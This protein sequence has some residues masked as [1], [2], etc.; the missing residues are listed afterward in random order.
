M[1]DQKADKNNSPQ[2]GTDAVVER[3]REF[4]RSQLREGAAPPRLSFALALVATEM[5]LAIASDP[6][7]VFPVVL[8]GITR[9][10]SNRSEAKVLQD[11]ECSVEGPA[12]PGNA[13][14]H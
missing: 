2:L 7:R 11:E 6:V 1:S 5:G 13:T 12:S 14:L 4:V 10:V 3:V 9:A 8:E